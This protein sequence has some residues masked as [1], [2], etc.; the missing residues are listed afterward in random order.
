MNAVFCRGDM[1]DP[2]NNKDFSNHPL[3]TTYSNQEHD[4]AIHH[5]YFPE[6]IEEL[7][8]RINHSIPV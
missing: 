5:I 3:L 1:E 2:W 8:E 6:I 7:V 4:N